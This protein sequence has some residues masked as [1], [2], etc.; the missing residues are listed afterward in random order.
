MEYRY[1]YRVVCYVDVIA[2]SEEDA[3]D[4]AYEYFPYE[5]DIDQLSLYESER[6][7]RDEMLADQINDE[8]RLGI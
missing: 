5:V 2:R 8:R 6:L 1:T 3:I 7:S 4:K